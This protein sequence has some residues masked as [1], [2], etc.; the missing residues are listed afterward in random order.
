MQILYAQ[1]PILVTLTMAA[2]VA[3]LIMGVITR[4]TLAQDK[5]KTSA[6]VVRVAVFSTEQGRLD[7]YRDFLEGHLFPTLRNVPG[8]FSRPS[9]VAT[10]TAVS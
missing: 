7:D 1:K 9:S 10:R 4:Q 8:Y 2:S 5:E 6:L 3:L